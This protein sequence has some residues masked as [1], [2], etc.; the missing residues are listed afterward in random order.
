MVKLDRKKSLKLVLLLAASL[1]LSLSLPA[2]GDYYSVIG[3]KHDMSGGTGADACSFCHTPAGT[4]QS[5]GWVKT[6]LNSASSRAYALRTANGSYASD[7][8]SIS[9]MCLSCHDNAMGGSVTPNFTH[10]TTRL[11]S[12]TQVDPNTSHPVSLPYPRAI[13]AGYY[14]PPDA[15]TGWQEVKLFA[16]SIECATCHDPHNPANGSFL[17]K[18]NRGSALCFT[19]HDK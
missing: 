15:E 17:R 14:V 18:S 4:D 10:D 3:S 12:R 9:M 19:C 11:V 13:K 1:Q 8:S 5:T 16:G 6:S 7:P 2:H